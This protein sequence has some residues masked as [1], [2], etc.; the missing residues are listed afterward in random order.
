M[1][2]KEKLTELESRIDNLEKKINNPSVAAATLGR[3]VTSKKTLTSR[4]NGKKGGR[5]RKDLSQH[6]N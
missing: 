4:E 6:R 3:K 1:D 5:P 2:L